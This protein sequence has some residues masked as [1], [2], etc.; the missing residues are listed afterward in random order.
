VFAAGPAWMNNQAPPPGYGQQQQPPPG[1]QGWQQSQVP[2]GFNPASGH[3][4]VRGHHDYPHPGEHF[5]TT[6]QLYSRY[7]TIFIG[8][9]IVGLIIM[10]KI[11]PVL[12]AAYEAVF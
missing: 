2:P 7:A 12:L 9:M 8:G 1:N 10:W 3:E 11:Y 6:K 4:S 5:F